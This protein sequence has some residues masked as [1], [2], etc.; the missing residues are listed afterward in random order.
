MK[1]LVVIGMVIGC[2]CLADMLTVP[3][4]LTV[5]SN[6]VSGPSTFTGGT[7][8]GPVTLVSA[9][10]T[11]TPIPGSFE[12]LNHTAYFTTYLVRRSLQLNQAIVTTPIT[13][14]NTVAETTLYSINMASNYITAGKVIVPKL[15]G[16]YWAANPQQ[17][18]LR[19][20]HQ[21]VTLLSTTS[22]TSGAT[23]KPWECV[24]TVTAVTD[25]AG[26]TLQA[27]TRLIQDTTINM[28]ALTNA[29]ALDTTTTNTLNITVQWS[30]TGAN[31]LQLN[32]G[33]TECIQ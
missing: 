28:D 22:T 7:N 24:W 20:K 32:Q 16:I 19:L 26:G 29:V 31:S 18:T 27:N 33:Y 11:S 14:S 9:P 10:L 17:F 3:G 5:R 12:Y 1:W 15:S 30:A 8:A 25:G 4:N 13:V 6:L 2:Q 21:G 23:A